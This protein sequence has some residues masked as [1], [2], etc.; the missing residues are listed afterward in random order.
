MGRTFFLMMVCFGLLLACDK[1]G[2]A[3][4]PADANAEGQASATATAATNDTPP[5]ASTGT[6]TLASANP[7]GLTCWT[8]AGLIEVEPGAKMLMLPGAG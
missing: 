2:E 3:K 7:P 1:E 6:Y 4:S 5:P 8:P